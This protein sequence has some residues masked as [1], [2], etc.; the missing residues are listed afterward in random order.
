MFTGEYMPQ[1]TQSTK[2][3][4]IESLED[5]LI[6]YMYDDFYNQ[7]NGFMLSLY[8]TYCKLCKENNYVVKDD[9]V[10]YYGGIDENT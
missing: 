5:T 7:L 2:I 4:I 10:D 1:L 3:K 6:I 8:E 9:I